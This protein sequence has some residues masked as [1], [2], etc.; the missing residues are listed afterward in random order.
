[1]LLV[2]GTGVTCMAR[3]HGA[4]LAE[5]PAVTPAALSDFRS[6]VQVLASGATTPYMHP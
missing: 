2:Q 5:H 3:T 4:V 6:R 1:M